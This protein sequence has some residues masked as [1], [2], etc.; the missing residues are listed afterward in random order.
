[1]KNVNQRR[2]YSNFKY[3]NDTCATALHESTDKFL[4][5]EGAVIR[6]GGEVDFVKC[7]P[8]EKI[9]KKNRN[10]LRKVTRIQAKPSER[11]TGING[12]G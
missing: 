9:A 5:D 11:P 8:Q 6:T 1:M 10:I 4:G 12:D 3:F 7:N 2:N